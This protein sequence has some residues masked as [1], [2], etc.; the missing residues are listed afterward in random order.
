MNQQAIMMND[1]GIIDNQDIVYRCYSSKKIITM[2]LDEMNVNSNYE[3]FSKNK[4]RGLLR[5]TSHK[6]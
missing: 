2:L 6:N 4:K 1:A 5:C 3:K